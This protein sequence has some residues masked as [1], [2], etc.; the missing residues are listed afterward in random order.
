MNACLWHFSA[1]VS[2]QFSRV[3]KSPSFPVLPSSGVITQNHLQNFWPL[4]LSHQTYLYCCCLRWMSYN[5]MDAEDALTLAMWKAYGKFPQYAAQIRQVRSWLTKLCY[6]TCL[7]LQRS[8]RPSMNLE[9]L[10]TEPGTPD[11]L[12]PYQCAIALETQDI[13]HQ[14]IQQLPL[15][16]RQAFTLRCVEEL[17]YLEISQRLEITEANARK[18][19]EQA[20]FKLRKLLKSE[21]REVI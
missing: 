4:W 16:L 6:R 15:P 13:I 7:D 19:V 10:E 14:A 8:V 17:S 12:S 5:T 18:R 21:L 11:Y 9:E 1:S 3:Q 20:K 2:T